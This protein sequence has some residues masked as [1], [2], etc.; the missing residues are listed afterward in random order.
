VS[1]LVLLRPAL[2]VSRSLELTSAER[3]PSPHVSMAR[4]EPRQARPPAPRTT[5]R[6]PKRDWLAPYLL[7]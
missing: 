1:L 4:D 6:K 5:R 7:H 2:R 3:R